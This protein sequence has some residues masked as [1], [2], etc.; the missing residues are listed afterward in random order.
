MKRPSKKEKV[1]EKKE[2][3]IK[4]ETPQRVK[5][6]VG[7]MERDFSYTKVFYL[8]CQQ[9]CVYVHLAKHEQDASTFYVSAPPSGM[10]M[11]PKYIKL[12][13]KDIEIVSEE[14]QKVADLL[15]IDFED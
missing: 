8:P 1:P 6:P 5:L 13:A 11:T 3:E 12:F 15:G 4:E 14:V 2:E 10:N 9:G 7:W